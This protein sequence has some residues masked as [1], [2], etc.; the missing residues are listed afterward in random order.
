MVNCNCNAY[1]FPHRPGGGKCLY[2]QVYDH[3]HDRYSFD[4][5]VAVFQGYH[6]NFDQI[7]REIYLDYGLVTS[8][9]YWQREYADMME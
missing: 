6:G 4:V 2:K 3:L 5:S 7:V 9:S 1:P 8:N